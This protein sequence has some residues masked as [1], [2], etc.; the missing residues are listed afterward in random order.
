MQTSRHGLRW[1]KRA[2][3][4]GFVPRAWA[5]HDSGRLSGPDTGGPRIGHF[6]A[7]DLRHAIEPTDRHEGSVLS[8]LPWMVS[9]AV[10][11]AGT[12][13][14]ATLSAVARLPVPGAMARGHEPR[15]RPESTTSPRRSPRTI[16]PP[17]RPPP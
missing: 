8:R 10:C 7:R 4:E 17:A 15:R 9:S 1:A 2:A 3:W 12:D 6:G 11:A 14:S 5:L 13:E 16:A